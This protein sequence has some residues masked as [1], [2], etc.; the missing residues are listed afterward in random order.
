MAK[1]E[2]L[3]PIL[4]FEG[5]KVPPKTK[6]RGMQTGEWDD[7][8]EEAMARRFAFEYKMVI[9][10]WK[11]TPAFY[12]D[13][14]GFPQ[15]EAFMKALNKVTIKRLARNLK[16]RWQFEDRLEIRK[17]RLNKKNNKFKQWLARE[18]SDEEEQKE[19]AR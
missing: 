16:E 8:D 5:R 10:D 11:K 19:K 1:F 14:N 7:D 6:T 17:E 15:T 4:E 12:V 3:V 18:D 13:N 9:D 2:E